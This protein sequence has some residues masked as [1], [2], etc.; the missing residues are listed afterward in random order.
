MIHKMAE[1]SG[2]VIG[3]WLTDNVV[4]VAVIIVAITIFTA[5]ITKKARDAFLAFGIAFL[6]FALLFIGANWSS[7][8][9][10]I[11]KTFLGG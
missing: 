4:F 5:A 3:K 9:D 6:G 2:N 10:W 8:S 11:G 1:V 7:F